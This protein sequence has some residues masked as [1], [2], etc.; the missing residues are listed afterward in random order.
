[1]GRVKIENCMMAGPGQMPP[2]PQPHPKH[3]APKMSLQSITLKSGLN[4]YLPNIDFFLC[5]NIYT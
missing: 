2:I 4:N 1:M 3:A 5:A